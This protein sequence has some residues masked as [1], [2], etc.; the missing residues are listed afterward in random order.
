MKKIIITAVVVFSIFS[1]SK[2]ADKVFEKSPDERRIESKQEF[3]KQLNSSNWVIELFTKS[4]EQIGGISIHTH[5]KEGFKVE[6]I[7]ELDKT[8]N[9]ETSSYSL[10]SRGGA[11]LSFDEYNKGIHSFSSP[12]SYFPKGAFGVADYEFIYLKRE[13]DIMYTKGVKTRN[14]IRFVATKKTAE[15]YFKDLKEVK[16]F[17]YRPKNMFYE[18]NVNGKKID[19]NRT[20]RLFKYNDNPEIKNIEKYQ[21]TSFVLTDKGIRFYQPFTVN[22]TE[23]FELFLD[24][25][26]N[27]LKSKDGKVQIKMFVTEIDFNEEYWNIE[28]Q[29]GLSCQ[30]ALDMYPA[31]N[32]AAKAHDKVGFEY[33]NL[34]KTIN[35]GHNKYGAPGIRFYTSTI[36]ETGYGFD[37][38]YKAIFKPFYDEKGNLGIYFLL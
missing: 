10:I 2:D 12:S 18:F 3:Q 37:G 22:G 32:E 24:K 1:C 30:K 29:P 9:A 6:I 28:L 34:T 27:S 31:V 36:R 35:L 17:I 23:V 20:R 11:L 26:S 4:H 16:K 19:F 15:Q 21:K 8:T 25:D 5:F 13:G 33:I 14:K 7:N 38:E